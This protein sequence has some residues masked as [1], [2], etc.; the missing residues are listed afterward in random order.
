M[1]SSQ[2]MSLIESNLPNK[3]HVLIIGDALDLL[4]YE[5]NSLI[6]IWIMNRMAFF[7]EWINQKWWNGQT[8]EIAVNKDKWDKGLNFEITF[9]VEVD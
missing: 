8:R 9:P 1:L 2:I 5:T 6:N 7:M 3:A 4:F